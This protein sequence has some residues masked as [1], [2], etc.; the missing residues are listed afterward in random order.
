MTYVGEMGSDLVYSERSAWGPDVDFAKRLQE[1]GVN[2][3]ELNV[4]SVAADNKRSGS[5]I[6][7][8]LYNILESVKSQVSIPVAVKLSPYYTSTSHVAAQLDE[9]KADGLVLFN[10]F[11]QPE[12]NAADDSSPPA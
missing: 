11:L 12:I 10:R 9:R 3:L 5:E 4:Y 8:E 2:A 7:A 6:E 1:A